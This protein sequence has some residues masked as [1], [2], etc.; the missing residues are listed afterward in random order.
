MLSRAAIRERNRK[1]EPIQPLNTTTYAVLLNILYF[2][3][4]AC[5]LIIMVQQKWP[6]LV[7]EQLF[8]YYFTITVALDPEENP[9]HVEG[10]TEFRCDGLALSTNYQWMINGTQ[11][12]SLSLPNV[13]TVL[14]GTHLQFTNTPLRYNGTTVQCTFTTRFGV[15]Q[16]ST[17]GTLL[18]QG[19]DSQLPSMYLSSSHYRV[20][21]CCF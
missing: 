1:C 9:I 10:A 19:N 13:N 12:E 21:G 2:T 7:R 17:V 15:P 5:I 6:K 14:E 3:N 20:V 4:G 8:K 18:V 16:S 11:F